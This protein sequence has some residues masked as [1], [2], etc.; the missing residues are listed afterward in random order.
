MQVSAISAFNDNYIWAIHDNRS[1]IVVDPGDSAPVEKFMADNQLQLTAIVITH[2]HRDHTGGIEALLKLSPQAVLYGPAN[3]KLPVTHKGLS[4][5]ETLSFTQ[6]QC[7][8][9][10]IAI[11]GHTLGHIA[12]YG[13]LGL[14][15]GDTLFHSGC[16]RIFEGT[17]AQMLDSLHQLAALPDPTL[18]YCAHEYTQANLA[19]AHQVEPDN[20][21]ISQAIEKVE[22]LRKKQ[23]PSLPSTIGEQ[24][25]I[26][27][28]LRCHSNTL[29]T[30]VELWSQKPCQSELE[31]FTQLRRWKDQF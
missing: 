24:K 13:S 10:V 15:C 6:P 23:Q 17:P 20:P 1:L 5:G 14:F 18:I 31:R 2:H 4:G 7:E 3:E 9:E 21:S 12:Y 29:K 28:F 8:F 25:Q 11:P 26:N 22:Q 16:G 27:P 19:F 30:N